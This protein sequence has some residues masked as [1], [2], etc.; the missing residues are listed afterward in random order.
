MI[1]VSIIKGK[2]IEYDY[3]EEKGNFP[4]MTKKLFLSNNQIL[5]FFVIPYLSFDYYFLKDGKF[6]FSCIT[7]SNQD[8]EKILMILQDIQ[9]K[10]YT[11]MSKE[12]DNLY[13]QITTILRKGIKKSL[14]ESKKIEII[15]KNNNEIKEEKIQILSD[16]I[17]KDN[18]INKN[19]EKKEHLQSDVRIIILLLYI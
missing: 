13:Y 16:C 19:Q 15:N 4:S 2:N 1:Y 14:L 9:T 17:E 3:T 7:N 11:L 5:N 10:F 18:L 6:T 12:K 8:N